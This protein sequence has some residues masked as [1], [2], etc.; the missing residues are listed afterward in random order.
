[1]HKFYFNILINIYRINE[2]LISFVLIFVI[3]KIFY[4]SFKINVLFLIFL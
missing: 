2:I 1:M 3:S 4:L